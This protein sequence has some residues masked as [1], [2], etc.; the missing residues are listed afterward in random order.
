MRS[1]L[2]PLGNARRFGCPT[3]VPC[4]RRS[5][6]RTADAEFD[7]SR[8]EPILDFVATD[9]TEFELLGLCP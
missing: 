2:E 1:V 8:D 7:L 4:E 9:K 6:P 3:R 5:I